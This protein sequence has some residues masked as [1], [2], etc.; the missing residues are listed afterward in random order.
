MQRGQFPLGDGEDIGGKPLQHSPQKYCRRPLIFERLDYRRYMGRNG[1]YVKQNVALDPSQQVAQHR[2]H[3][4]GDGV[5]LGEG[6]GSKKQIQ[7][8]GTEVRRRKAREKED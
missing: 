8:R 4:G 2:Q 3:L 7:H 6:W 1:R 5:G